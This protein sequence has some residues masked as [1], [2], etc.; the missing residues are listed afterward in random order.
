M[1]LMD[2]KIASLEKDL[3]E[4]KKQ[5]VETQINAYYEKHE[6]MEDTKVSAAIAMYKTKLQMAQEAQDPEFDK[7]NWD[8]EGWKARLAELDDKEEAGE[9]LTIEASGSGKDQAG[10]DAGAGG[11]G[12]GDA[13]NV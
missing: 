1:L 9:V 7:S 5:V 10:G 2:Q 8:I 6:I 3:N 12:E 4:A 13:A 11:A